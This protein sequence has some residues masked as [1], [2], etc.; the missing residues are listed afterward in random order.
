[1]ISAPRIRTV[2]LFVVSYVISISLLPLSQLM[3]TEFRV[4]IFPK[5]CICFI[6]PYFHVFCHF[7]TLLLYTN[8]LIYVC[9]GVY[10][11][12]SLRDN[13]NSSAKFPSNHK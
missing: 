10:D 8:S 7:V 5:K 13:C 12:A 6:F 9:T 2:G 11:D 4:V 1:M 3:S